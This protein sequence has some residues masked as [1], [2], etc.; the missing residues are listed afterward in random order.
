MVPYSE[1]RNEKWRLQWWW[2]CVDITMMSQWARWRPKPL[3]LDC[4]LRRR[5]KKASQ[6]RVTGLC[7]G[8]SPETGE[9]PA[10]MASKT[11]NVSIWWRHYGTNWLG[12][13]L[14]SSF[15]TR[16]Y[17][18]SLR[19]KLYRSN[20]TERYLSYLFQPRVSRS[21]PTGY[22]SFLSLNET[23][24]WQNVLSV[25]ES[26]QKRFHY[27]ENVF[28]KLTEMLNTLLTYV[29]ELNSSKFAHLN[30]GI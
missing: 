30:H 1:D 27:S 19:P 13:L 2:Q 25:D 21:F 17:T 22:S 7:E 3:R 20:F 6:L 26:C 5:S 14:V 16:R 28:R 4:L 23:S 15:T 10:Q 8:N 24:D 9:F 18:G 12:T 29:T 11:E